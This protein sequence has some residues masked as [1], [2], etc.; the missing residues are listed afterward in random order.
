M[1]KFMNSDEYSWEMTKTMSFDA[2][3]PIFI[4][5]HVLWSTFINYLPVLIRT[6]EIE[7]SWWVNMDFFINIGQNSWV[8]VK[9]I[10]L[11]QYIDEFLWEIIVCMIINYNDI[12]PSLNMI[13]LKL[14]ITFFY[15]SSTGILRK[16]TIAC[17]GCCW[18]EDG[19]ETQII[20]PPAIAASWGG[21]IGPGTGADEA[22]W[23]L[24]LIH[25][26]RYYKWHKTK[27]IK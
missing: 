6:D 25:W 9:F 1:A 10:I 20:W 7:Q 23:V 12:L 16:H 3:S 26:T 5:I 17:T 18:G 27:I 15:H 11:Y 24:K 2:Y 14:F 22:P 8:Y 21:G 13:L 19:F 4:T